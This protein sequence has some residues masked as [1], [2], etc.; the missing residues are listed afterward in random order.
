MGDV[1]ESSLHVDSVLRDS[2][3]VLFMTGLIFKTFTGRALT[4]SWLLLGV[5]NE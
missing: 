4:I 3:D 2:S 5:I 1:I